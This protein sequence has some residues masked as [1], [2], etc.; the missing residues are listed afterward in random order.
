LTVASSGG[1]ARDAWVRGQ[2][3]AVDGEAAGRALWLG[4]FDEV[5]RDL[6]GW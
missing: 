1:G 6:F 2:Q 5:L 3:Q 4:E